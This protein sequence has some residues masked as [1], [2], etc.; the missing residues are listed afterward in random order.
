[1]EALGKTEQPLWAN[2]Q[3]NQQTK[4]VVPIVEVRIAAV[5]KSDANTLMWWI[6]SGVTKTLVELAA[7]EMVRG[8]KRTL[9]QAWIK[10]R[11]LV[12]ILC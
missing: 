9:N 3:N 7:A 8:A 2:K 10:R 12:T 5:R 1:M 11:S 4:E 6:L